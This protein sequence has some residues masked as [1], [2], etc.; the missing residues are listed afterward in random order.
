MNIQ[1]RFFINTFMPELLAIDALPI[2]VQAAGED[3]DQE[4]LIRQKGYP[5]YHAM[6]SVSG[7][8]VLETSKGCFDVPPH[9]VF[10]IAPNQPH[11]YYPKCGRWHTCWVVFDGADSNEIFYRLKLITGIP[12][13]LPD[14]KMFNQL[15]H[16]ICG[17]AQENTVQGLYRASGHCYSLLAVL[18]LDMR[19]QGGCALSESAKARISPVLAYIHDNYVRDIGLEQMAECIGVTPQYLCSLFQNA[20]AMSPCRYLQLYRLKKAKELLAD[21]N[22][23]AGAAGARCGFHDAS[24]FC[25]VFKKQVG[26]TPKEFRK[27]FGGTTTKIASENNIDVKF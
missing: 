24:Y 5:A 23:P 11:R 15:Y 12:F 14:V 7:T 21:R 27:I 26:F 13:E 22:L 19:E 18:S 3:T 4:C 2:M 9:H 25:A 1:E 10:M 20:L 17:C 16:K 6:L 8:G